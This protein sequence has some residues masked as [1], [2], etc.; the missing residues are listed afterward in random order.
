MKLKILKTLFIL[1]MSYTVFALDID[2]QLAIP[3]CS[4]TLAP[5]VQ[6]ED[7]EVHS[8]S[9]FTIC[10]RESFEEAE[11]VAYVLTREELNAVTGRTDDFRE[12]PLISTGSASLNDYRKSGYDRGH[13]APAADMEWS[14][15]STHESF[16]LSNMTP[17]APSFN[18]GMWKKLEEAVRDW[19]YRYGAVYVVTGP[20]LEKSADS[21]QSIGENKVA[22]PEY[23]YKALLSQKEDGTYIA[24]AFIMPNTKC[25]GSIWDYE[26]TIDELEERTSI[27]FFYLLDDNIED[28]IEMQIKD[29]DWK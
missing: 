26:V 20:V 2:E 17:Q 4:A 22:V 27:D 15:R 19:A 3:H 25:E 9:G 12:D 13:L 23:F 24:M 29:D 14:E 8:Y 11:W 28:A 1:L 5:S 6:S 21:Y 16:L 18:R 10:Y 7:H